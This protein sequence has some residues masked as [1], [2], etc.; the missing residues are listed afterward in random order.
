[1]CWPTGTNSSGIGDVCEAAGP[2]GRRAEA[3]WFASLVRLRLG[4]FAQGW[5]EYEWRWQQESWVPQ[6]RDFA[7]PLW[8]GM[9]PLAGK[10]ILL[11]AEQGYGDTLQF[12]RYVK[13]VA[14]SG[15]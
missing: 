10:T 15:R 4:Q 5:H 11:H 2:E 13:L 1:M 7:A 9:E 12:I 6:R 14:Q 3:H 8:R